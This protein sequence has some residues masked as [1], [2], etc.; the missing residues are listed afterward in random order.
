MINSQ[1]S[2]L[3]IGAGAIGT[4]IA[5]WLAPFVEDFTVLDQGD[6]LAA[7]KQ[8]GYQQYGAGRNRASQQQQ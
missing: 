4:S 3:L 5:T 8:N 1:P 6:T 7:I 2:V